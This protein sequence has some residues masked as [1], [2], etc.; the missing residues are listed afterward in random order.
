VTVGGHALQDFVRIIERRGHQVG[1]LVGGITEHDALIARAFVL[2]T[3]FIHALRDVR[4]LWVEVV[5]EFQRVPVE[6]VLFVTNL[7]YRRAYRSFDFRQRTVG[8]F[9][10]GIDHPISANFA[11]QNNTLRRH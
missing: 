10:F 8:P 1:R 11:S 3:A 5:G 6:S 7:L 4:G 9:A 2:V